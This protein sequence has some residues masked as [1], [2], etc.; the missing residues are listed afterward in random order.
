[1]D[2]G[3]NT[4]LK[5]FETFTFSY[6]S[7]NVFQLKLTHNTSATEFTINNALLSVG[8]SGVVPIV[9][10][11]SVFMK[12]YTQNVSSLTSYS[13]TESDSRYYTQQQITDFLSSKAPI[14][15]PTF[16]G[17]LTTPSITINGT[18]LSTTLASKANVSDVFTKAEVD[19]RFVNL[20]DNAPV[21]LD[22]LNELASALGNNPNYATTITTQL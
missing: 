13:K 12:H 7:D 18:P 17:T 2:T 8:F 1:L 15:N 4:N 21:A 11:E 5:L 19:Q 9:S 20:I 6:A 3:N 14:N 16:T 22:T 10:L